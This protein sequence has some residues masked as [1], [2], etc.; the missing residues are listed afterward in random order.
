MSTFLEA[1][2]KKQ[3]EQRAKEAKSSTAGDVGF[4]IGV[5]DAI[6][7]SV[8]KRI[9]NQSGKPVKASKQ[10]L[11]IS[12]GRAHIRGV[13]GL[14]GLAEILKNLR[15]N[16]A[17][18]LGTPRGQVDAYG[19]FTL[20]PRDQAD[21]FRDHPSVIARTLEYYSWPKDG[22]FLLLDHDPEPGRPELNA[23]EFWAELSRVVPEL[24]GVGRVT[25]VSTSSA[26]YEKATGRCL[27]PATG[28][29]TYIPVRGDVARLVELLKVRCWAHGAAFHKLASPNAQTGVAS[30][31]ERFIT[32]L[33]VFSPERLV[34]EAGAIVPDEWEQRRPA[35]R[36]AE[37]GLLNLDALPEPT[38][39]E[40]EAAETAKRVS[41]EALNIQRCGDV[42]AFVKA[43]SPDKPV[44]EC[45]REAKRRISICDRFQL[46]PDHKLYLAT[47]ETIMVSQISANHH[48]MGLKDPLEPDYREGRT[49]LAKIY[50]SKDSWVIN[51]FA[52]GG[53][54]FYQASKK[55]GFSP[56]FKK[57]SEA[58][59]LAKEHSNWVKVALERSPS[60]TFA[61]PPDLFE[62]GPDA[63][64]AWEYSD[65]AK[66]EADIKR[67]QEIT[68]RAL[69]FTPEY[70]QMILNRNVDFDSETLQ[71]LQN[72]G[73]PVV[74]TG[75]T[76]GGKTELAT[77]VCRAQGVNNA[78]GIAP[79]NALAE[80]MASRVRSK[81]LPAYS[82]RGSE[83]IGKH[84]LRASA[85]ESLYRLK[86]EFLD[87]TALDEPDT[88][89]PRI[90][91]G[92][93]GDA[94][95]ANL[96]QL[97]RVIK[98]APTQ[99]WL[100]A[101]ISPVT[102]DLL[103]AIS[104][105]KPWVVDLQREKPGAKPVDVSIYQ[106]YEELGDKGPYTVKMRPQFH[107]NLISAAKSGKKI[108]YLAGSADMGR[109][110]H[111]ELKRFKISVARRDGRYTTQSAKNGFSAQPDVDLAGFQV[112]IVS[113]LAET[114][115]DLQQGYDAVFVDLSPS[116]SGFEANQF[117]SRARSL[118]RGETPQL[119]LW[120][121]E[122]P[123]SIEK[124]SAE[125]WAEKALKESSDYLDLL[126]S[127]MKDARE[128][129]AELRWVSEFWGKYQARHHASIYFKE[130]VLEGI[131]KR[132]DWNVDRVM[133]TG[134]DGGLKDR[135][136]WH[137]ESA[138][139][140]GDM[141]QARAPRE[142][143]GFSDPQRFIKYASSTIPDASGHADK[144]ASKLSDPNE[145]GWLI[146][147]QRT[148]LELAKWF[149]S[150]PVDMA[151]WITQ[152]RLERN[153][154]LKNQSILRAAV[155]EADGLLLTRKLC[156]EQLS[157]NIELHGP[158]QGIKELSKSRHFLSMVLGSELA[159]QPFIQRVL[160]GNDAIHKG[161][162]DVCRFAEW[163]RERE[164]TF[165]CWSRNAL[166]REFDFVE[167]KQ[168]VALVLK[169]LDK[170]LGI[171]NEGI[172]KERV[173]G[174]LLRVYRTELS[175]EGRAAILAADVE[176]ALECE[177][178]PFDDPHRFL[179][180]LPKGH[181]KAAIT[182]YFSARFDFTAGI[183]RA[184]CDG[185]KQQVEWTENR[186]VEFETETSTQQGIRS[187]EALNSRA[188]SI[189]QEFSAS[190]GSNTDIKGISPPSWTGPPPTISHPASSAWT[191][192]QRGLI[193]A[194]TWDELQKL[195]AAT[196]PQLRRDVMFQWSRDHRY[197][198]LAAK[199][200]W[201][202]QLTTA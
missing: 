36:V 140:T 70:N 1:I 171:R 138:L 163:V 127:E 147:Q 90:L 20:F 190:K 191:T 144:W 198:W 176:K 120:L 69:D 95:D 31:L 168:D 26:I 178:L 80:Q 107:R 139:R 92:S 4:K 13:A 15:K 6:V 134:D 151:T 11:S 82:I 113:R 60:A 77:Q 85:A 196:N 83:D 156:D 88:W 112:Q 50:W 37:G 145:A 130:S 97:Q 87:F 124:L 75:A 8:Q 103:T 182:N 32:D 146:Q 86:G 201:L 155:M 135:L 195:K 21:A 183:V 100:N 158:L 43:Q 111:Q 177:G 34:Y 175:P 131:F 179:A 165:N 10:Q 18:T 98:D 9:V 45:K 68:E 167:A 81:G 39:A 110:V 133:S 136:A 189:L 72:K 58:S 115:I 38:T 197:E 162:E 22:H 42:T 152:L 41:W 106:D 125:Y 2:K 28:H 48:E 149:P 61:M 7:G 16:Q 143:L 123:L 35:P 52:H 109:A 161:M 94:A 181:Q 55:E 157:H 46:E 200:E 23:D 40:R 166:K 202:K 186:L 56:L 65:L 185:W 150:A 96:V 54:K 73:I 148:K 180:S 184:A 105:Q 19:D 51:S 126:Q 164:D 63:W 172:G 44:A 174:R 24:A 104:G 12:S 30:I 14:H 53:R 129:L 118:L 116:M 101:E 108:L 188:K 159:K 199:A 17:L 169:V 102:I 122:S 67:A 194:K 160:A 117:L 74:V 89:L 33:T 142:M 93:L 132:L 27:K 119:K 66:I 29:H 62:R 57:K 64:K 173:N 193:E 47:G 3:A 84:G 78:H 79:T 137:K 128:K 154:D 192:F 153:G 170:V 141:A 99:L 25:T 49:D 76:G 187:S 59:K 91:K 5:V 114:G 121:P 71:S